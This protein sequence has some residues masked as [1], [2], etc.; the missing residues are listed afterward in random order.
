M[1]SA[2]QLKRY[3]ANAYIFDIVIS[4]LD[5]KQEPSIV[6]LLKVNKSSKI[7][8]SSTILLLHLAVCL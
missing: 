2:I 5:Y 6:I 4:K 7:D 3:M 8:L 1:V